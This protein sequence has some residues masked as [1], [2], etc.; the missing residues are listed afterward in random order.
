[1][2]GSVA[3]GVLLFVMLLLNALVA[4]PALHHFWHA[5][6]GGGDFGHD[7]HGDHVHPVSQGEAPGHAHEG[8]AGGGGGCAQ[9]D[10]VVL[11]FAQGKL[12]GGAPVMPWARPE[13]VPHVQ[14]PISVDVP[15][16]REDWSEPQGRGP[17][18]V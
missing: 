1:M 18:Q 11:A 13:L 8:E 2:R 5:T 14:P 4:V 17:P 7:H 3:G 15:V 10:C 9:P 12:E 16:L 6:D